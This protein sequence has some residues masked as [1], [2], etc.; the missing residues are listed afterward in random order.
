M[1]TKAKKAIRAKSVKASGRSRTRQQL[2]EP[3]KEPRQQRSQQTVRRI[4]EAAVRLLSRTGVEG[5]T[6]NHIA[7]E[8]GLS[9]AS[10]YQFFPNKQ[11]IVNAAYRDWVE[12]LDAQILEVAQQIK[13][14]VPWY[15]F[16]GRLAD[17]MGQYRFSSEEE[18]ELLRAMWS[19]RELLDVD[20][21]RSQTNA[22]WIA[23][24][25]IAYGA[26]LPREK[27]VALA[28]FA[29]G[30]FTLASETSVGKSAQAQADITSFARQAYVYLW[31][32]ALTPQPGHVDETAVVRV[33]PK[34]RA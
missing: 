13:G 34:K 28:D 5:L 11:A 29:N 14:R 17:R 31:S 18:F 6:T 25:M 33:S 3:K 20:R 10:V 26:T 8:A 7:D 21:R 12:T 23:D 32:T 30:L 15:E 22:E 4:I 2:T 1:T 9:V 27:L 24:C 16:A 19:H